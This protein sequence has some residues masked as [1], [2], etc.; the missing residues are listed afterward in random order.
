MKNLMLI[1]STINRKINTEVEKK[2]MK[3]YI[4]YHFLPLT[5]IMSTSPGLPDGT[6]PSPNNL[7]ASLIN[8]YKIR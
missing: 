6:P 3:K 5:K 1:L 2:K 8:G 4:K 7:K